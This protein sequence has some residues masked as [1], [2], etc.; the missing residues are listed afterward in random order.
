MTNLSYIKGN[1]VNHLYLINKINDT[2][3]KVIEV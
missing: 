1:C 3:E 2:S